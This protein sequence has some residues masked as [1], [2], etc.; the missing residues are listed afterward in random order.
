MT[1]LGSSFPVSRMILGYP[2]LTGQALR[3]A[4]AA[5]VLGALVRRGPM[6]SGKQIARLV[7]LAATGLVGFNICVLNA[8]RAA[9]APLVGTVV[10]GTPLVLALLGP[11]LA[12]QRPGIRVVAAAGI[13]VVGVALVEGGGHTSAAGLGWALG[14]LAGEVLFSLIAAPLLPELG[15]LRVSAWACA[16]AVPQLLTAALVTGE[17]RRWRIPTGTETAAL[18][19]IALALTVAA[20]LLWYSGLRRL[21]LARA[22]M[23]AGV[24][25]VAAL[26]T[27]ALLDGQRPGALSLAGTAVV[28]IGLAGGRYAERSAARTSSA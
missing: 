27:T 8:L 6:P 7:A 24:L 23:F 13:V 16:L 26:A 9:D 20:F 14:A 15:P 22:G 28:A 12:R 17:W 11:A 5:L 3:Y 2:V 4:L 10:G 25:P 19:Y 1:I 21:G 18:L